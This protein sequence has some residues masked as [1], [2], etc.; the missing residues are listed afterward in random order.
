MNKRRLASFLKS[1]SIM[2]RSVGLRRLMVALLLVLVGHSTVPAEDSPQSLLEQAENQLVQAETYYWFGM[3]E[4]GSNSSFNLATDLLDQLE[5]DFA[6]LE[7]NPNVYSGD[8]VQALRAQAAGLRQDLRQQREMARD[9]VYGVFPLA[10][11][12]SGTIFADSTILGTYELIDDPRVMASTAAVSAMIETLINQRK[13]LD[14]VFT[15]KNLDL[16]KTLSPDLENEALYLFNADP[17]FFVHNRREVVDALSQQK[18]SED[19]LGKFEKQEFTEPIRNAL[20]RAFDTNRILIVQIEEKPSRAKDSFFVVTGAI[21]EQD[22]KDPVQIIRNMGFSRDRSAMLLYLVVA[23][24][25][26]ALLALL[27]VWF[28]HK[29]RLDSHP[30]Q[31]PAI[32]ITMFCAF[33]LARFL[34]WSS[35]PTVYALLPIPP[36]ETL[37][38]VGW[39]SPV[40]AGGLIGFLP[41]IILKGANVSLQRFMPLGGLSGHLDLAGI[42]V[43]FGA[44]AWWL[45]PLALYEGQ[46][47]EAVW[48]S[49]VLM[50]P[51][52]LSSYCLGRSLDRGGSGVWAV[53][54]G[55][56]VVLHAPAVATYEWK[57]LTLYAVASIVLWG[58]FLALINRRLKDSFLKSREEADQAG[59]KNRLEWVHPSYKTLQSTAGELSHGVNLVLIEDADEVG[60]SY[61]VDSW[62][63]SIYPEPHI[64]R[65]T[66]PT[67]EAAPY[68]T[69]NMLLDRPLVSE[70]TESIDQAMGL[71]T[72]FIPFGGLLAL[73]GSSEK[74]TPE[75]LNEAATQEIIQRYK[76][77]PHLVVVIDAIED[78]DESSAGWIKYFRGRPYREHIDL[79]LVG[80]SQ[81]FEPPIESGDGVRR[82]TIKQLDKDALEGYLRDVEGAT[83][84]LAKEMLKELHSIDSS[85]SLSEL[86]SCIE[87]LQ[88]RKAIRNATNGWQISNEALFRELIN[89]PST[90]A[91]ESH[92]REL[93]RRVDD[94]R[95]LVTAAACLGERFDLHVTARALGKP[96]ISV[97]D[98]L[99]KLSGE[100]GFIHAVP[101]EDDLYGF[102]NRSTWAATRIVLGI[103]KGSEDL[104]SLNRVF[105]QQVAESLEK[106][107][108]TAPEHISKLFFLFE[109]AG[110]RQATK[111][112]KYG[113]IVVR[114]LTTA[115][116]FQKAITTLDKCS[117]YARSGGPQV[118]AEMEKLIAVE[119]DRTNLDKLADSPA[120]GQDPVSEALQI[121]SRWRARGQLP[122]K[123]IYPVLRALYGR[124]NGSDAREVFKRVLSDVRGVTSY[125]AWLQAEILHYQALSL[126]S[127]EHCSDESKTTARLM[128]D[129]ALDSISNSDDA[130]N[131][132]ARSRVLTSL[133]NQFSQTEDVKSMLEE[134]IMLKE[135]FN[136][137]IGLAMAIG[138][139]ARSLF[140]QEEVSQALPKIARWLVLNK[141]IGDKPA[142]AM[143]EN[144]QGKAYVVLYKKTPDDENL[145]KEALAAF[146]R[147]VL[148]ATPE[149]DISIKI[150]AALALADR[151]QLMQY[152]EDEEAYRETAAELAQ[153]LSKMGRIN[154]L[155]IRKKLRD[156]AS[157][158]AM[159]N[160]EA[161]QQIYQSTVDPDPPRWKVAGA[162]VR[163]PSH[164]QSGLPCQDAHRYKV[165]N[166]R[167]TAVVSDGAGSCRFSE[168]GARHLSSHL[169]DSL[170]GMPAECELLDHMGG[171][172]DKW[173][174]KVEECIRDVQSSIVAQYVQANPVATDTDSVQEL[175]TLD[176]FSATL[177]G[178]VAG[179]EGGFF[180]HIGD[181]CAVAVHGLTSDSPDWDNC[182]VS[183]AQNGEDVNQ[184]YFF[185]ARNAVD[186]DL[187]F[188]A[189]APT[190]MVIL[191]TDG[192][193]GFTM[194]NTG[195][196]LAPGV[197]P[198]L[199]PWM[200]KTSEAEIES[201]FKKNML[202]GE[203]SR[204]IDGDDKTLLCALLC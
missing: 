162:S 201:F 113:L 171:I 178:V 39:W 83:K 170:A 118:R 2:W 95:D 89:K 190:Q 204:E 136:D 23:N 191:M 197:I 137:K 94:S 3:A 65:I 176:D 131:L 117:G 189:F 26:L 53:L 47:S 17:K 135:R 151:M 153:F 82:I 85:I 22:T 52:V 147:V 183:E 84:E 160:D 73:G 140:F 7:K 126:L 44:A 123:L 34:P 72:T 5:D 35:L 81:P 99:E 50:A 181:G 187:R 159:G 154:A 148:L 110:I 62:C 122:E 9:T 13:N 194:I 129:Q 128:F 193:S 42:G 43:G 77:F 112:I 192:A 105:Y 163:G 127:A 196:R 24:I 86:K 40:L 184:T 98:Q 115:R 61:L 64:V 120:S 102:R 15:S 121:E 68:S 67:A 138:A 55:L 88:E 92:I 57:F 63:R 173:K 71:V 8:D 168:F 60:R 202:D 114:S 169:V 41:L 199:E 79:V 59:N 90:K 195:N 101:G 109:R 107:E 14:V 19:L 96:V 143:A 51:L 1:H 16:N 78:M 56:L 119:R 36:P 108:S 198:K 66:C 80:K 69:L 91:A 20:F 179:P 134:A 155:W 175:P 104:S 106:E 152:R 74:A 146:A 124:N 185:T 21:Y 103:E 10:R 25:T 177:V 58:G 100:S 158:K 180:F 125:P 144:F 157:W 28:L 116:N 172:S 166:D 75:Q 70:E 32:L 186:A 11:F 49:I 93:L 29:Q 174:S 182:T 4:K 139:L 145:Y 203:Q 97:A 12:L 37:A 142:E 167:L 38:I 45:T 156:A 54:F 31:V 200:K 188:T 130:E 164:E 161:I 132:A 111:A 150:Q 133:A 6:E 165:I 46:V 76:P 48:L 27:F 141:E 30:E 33:L 18:G 149:A 87:L